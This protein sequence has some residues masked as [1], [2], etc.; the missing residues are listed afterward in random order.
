MFKDGLRRD[1]AHACDCWN[2]K[3]AG[4]IAGGSDSNNYVTVT[5]GTKR[6]K[7]TH[8][9]WLLVKGALPTKIIDHRD[10][11]PSNNRWKNLRYCKWFN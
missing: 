4:K 3:Y 11:D 2:T 5:Y 6:Y 9:I 7:A 8:I 10:G 1:A